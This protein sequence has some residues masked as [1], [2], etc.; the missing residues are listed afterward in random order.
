MDLHDLTSFMYRPLEYPLF[1]LPFIFAAGA[2]V[3]SL[4]NV[5]IYR[6]PLEKSILWPSSRCSSCLHSIRAVDNIPLLSYLRLKGKCRHCGATYS[7]RYFWI[8]LATAVLFAGSYY[9]VMTLNDWQPTHPGEV[10]FFRSASKAGLFVM[11]L[12][13]AFFLSFLIVVTFTDIDHREI[14]LTVTIPGTI[15]GLIFST[16]LPWPAPL[17][18]TV[19]STAVFGGVGLPDDMIFFL[20]QAAQPWPLWLPS[21]DWLPPGSW[22][23][24]LAT[25]LFGAAFGTGMIRALRWVFGWGFGKEAMGIGD[26]DLMMMIG[27][28]MGWQATVL[29]LLIA[30]FL[31]LFYALFTFIASR[32]NEMPFGPFLAA[33]ALALLWGPLLGLNFGYILTQKTF[34]DGLLLVQLG[35]LAAGLAILLCFLIRMARLIRLA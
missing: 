16:L 27:A 6:L 32:Q 10:N 15:I 17:R 3:G 34:F 1:M 2:I 11:W 31:G 13:Q 26:A 18:L 25:G 22:Q 20:P 23:L 7:A 30:V 24:G 4:L 28:F 9:L 14:P 29:V 12:S 8:E 33:A 35:G 19:P 5:C 21:F